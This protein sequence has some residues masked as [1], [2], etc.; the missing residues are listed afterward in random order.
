[1]YEKDFV[2]RFGDNMGSLW[3]RLLSIIKDKQTNKTLLLSL[4]LT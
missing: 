4:L 2:Y 1:M 3:W